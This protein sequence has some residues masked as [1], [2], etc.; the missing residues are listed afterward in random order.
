MIGCDLLSWDDMNAHLFSN[1]KIGCSIFCK[2]SQHNR[3][4]ARKTEIVSPLFL[5]FCTRNRKRTRFNEFLE[6][7]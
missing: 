6:M 3:R 1:G 5:S 4:F 7:K 2:H